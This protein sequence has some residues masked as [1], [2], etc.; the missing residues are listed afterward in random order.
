VRHLA[1]PTGLPGRPNEICAR[2]GHDI[3]CMVHGFKWSCGRFSRRGGD[4][5]HPQIP[6]EAVEA[7]RDAS[8]DEEGT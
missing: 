7:G 5:N 1:V 6:D 4:V 3:R 2:C 8:L